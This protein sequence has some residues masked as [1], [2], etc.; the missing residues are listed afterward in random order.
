MSFYEAMQGNFA[1]IAP[2]ELAPDL[3]GFDIDAFLARL[4]PADSIAA[5]HTVGL[6]DVIAGH[7]R[8]GERRPAGVAA[9]RSWRATATAGSS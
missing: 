8:A 6:V 7:P 9:K 5:R 3:A 2:A 4:Q 1:G